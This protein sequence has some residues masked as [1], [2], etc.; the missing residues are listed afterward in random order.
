MAS[1]VQQQR[2]PLEDDLLATGPLRPKSNKR[3]ARRGDDEGERFVD[4]KSSRKILKIGRDL[5]D[6][7]EELSTEDAPDNAFA[8]ESRQTQTENDAI[9]D[10]AAIEEREDAWEDDDEAEAAGNVGS[11]AEADHVSDCC[12]GN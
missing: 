3:K 11:Q 6:E 7:D 12:A 1:T 9:V 8:F 2:R 5:H 10:D 4:S